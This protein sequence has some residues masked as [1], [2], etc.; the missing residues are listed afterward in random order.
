MFQ[1]KPF[2]SGFYDPSQ[3]PS[4]RRDVSITVEFTVT[5]EDMEDD[6][7]PWIGMEYMAES[8]DQRCQ[9]KPG[10]PGCESQW[11]EVK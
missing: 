9:V 6:T 2:L 3:D 8:K 4:N 1:N 10:E 5:N 11:W 7:S